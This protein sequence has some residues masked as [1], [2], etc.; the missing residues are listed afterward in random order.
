MYTPRFVHF[1]A[2]KLHLNLTYE[3]PNL[4]YYWEEIISPTTNLYF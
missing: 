3:I 4:S 1:M 2:C